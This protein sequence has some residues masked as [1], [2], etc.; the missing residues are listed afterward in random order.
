[1]R[2]VTE[3]FGIY[4]TAVP[5]MLKNFISFISFPSSCLGTALPAK[6]CFALARSQAK[7]GLHFGSQVQLGNQIK[8]FCNR[9]GSLRKKTEKPG[10]RSAQSPSAAV[11]DPL[12]E[13][14]DR[15]GLGDGHQGHL[16]AVALD[17]LPASHL[18]FRVIA[19]L[20]KKVGPE[21]G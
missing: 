2:D 15:D 10:A 5:P 1:M 18:L 14:G 13:A 9:K 12:D 11:L 20:G 8:V 3:G 6:L 17:D 16:A 21:P 7:L 4:M 19:P